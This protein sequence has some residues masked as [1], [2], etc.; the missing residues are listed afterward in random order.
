MVSTLS[1]NHI[2]GIIALLS[3]TILDLQ[4]GAW[5]K[6]KKVER[7]KLLSEIKWP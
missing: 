6:V 5:A 2:P 4:K 3:A 7:E 1:T